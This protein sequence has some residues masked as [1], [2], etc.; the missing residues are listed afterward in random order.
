[1]RIA[2][3]INTSPK[4]L[5]TT[6]GKIFAVAIIA[7]SSCYTHGTSLIVRHDYGDLSTYTPHPNVTYEV[8]LL[9]LALEKT[10]TDYGEYR[11]E[12]VNKGY[13]TH[14]RAMTLMN[15]KKIENYVKVLGYNEA[16]QDSHRLDIAIF[17]VYLGLLSY[18]SC[19][20]SQNAAKK[21]SSIQS[22][23]DFKRLVHASGVGW[24]DTAIMRANGIDVK[25][26]PNRNAIYKMLELN[27]IDLFCRGTNEALEDFKDNKKIQGITYDRSIAMH[28]PNPHFFHVHMDNQTLIERLETGLERA[29]KDGSLLTLWSATFRDSVT[30]VE[31]KKRRIFYFDNPYIGKLPINYQDYDFVNF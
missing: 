11:I 1:M 13:M 20:T 15:E 2:S 17:P 28:Y 25:E 4:I 30:F 23:T 8:K 19:F 6:V 22:V 14:L 31:M 27:R 18:R 3:W 12:G 16:L 26:S 29:F 10:K 24:A 9:E 21:I 7:F 5:C